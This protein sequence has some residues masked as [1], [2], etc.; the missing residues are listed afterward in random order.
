MKQRFLLFILGAILCAYSAKGQSVMLLTPANN[1]IGILPYPSFSWQLIGSSHPTLSYTFKIAVYDAG[2][3]DAASIA[4]P[5]Y[6]EVISDN[7]NFINY[8]YPTTLAMLDSCEQ[9]VWQVT[10]SYVGYTTE[11]PIEPVTNL[12]AS[13]PYFHFASYCVV[14]DPSEEDADAIAPSR[15]YLVPQRTVDNFVYA[16]TTDSLYFKYEEPYK[17]DS[18][19]YRIYSNENNVAA[20]ANLPVSYGVNY[21]AI[22]ISDEDIE[23]SPKIYTLEIKLPKGEI[24]RAKFEKKTL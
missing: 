23:V 22:D 15:I 21:K 7:S 9:Y 1:S 3:G 17:N 12:Y 14:T 18:I 5:L 24:L 11:E 19:Q 6:S 16:V 10:A 4:T 13:S 8:N 2:I 20:S